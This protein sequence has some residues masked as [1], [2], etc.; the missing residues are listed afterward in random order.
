MVTVRKKSIWINSLVLYRRVKKAMCVVLKDPYMIL[1]NF[2]NHCTLDSMRLLLHLAYPW[3]HK[4]IMC[5]S[6][7]SQGDHVP[8][9]R[10]SWGLMFG[11][12]LLCD[13]HVF[14]L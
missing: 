9:F 5:M 6:K 7:N 2:S 8:Y 3:F 12:I 4:T 14:F 1:S 11:C 13:I 10:T